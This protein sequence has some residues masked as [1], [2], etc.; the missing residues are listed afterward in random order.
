MCL[1]Q[2]KLAEFHKFS[3]EQRLEL[4]IRVCIASPSKVKAV[5]AFNILAH[6]LLPFIVTY[7]K[8]AMESRLKQC[9]LR[10]SGYSSIGFEAIVI[11]AKQ[12]QSGDFEVFASLEGMFSSHPFFRPTPF[13]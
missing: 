5:D 11:L 6:H 10:I 7:E 1:N 8:T 9:F 3:P 2:L 4:L 13:G 12:W